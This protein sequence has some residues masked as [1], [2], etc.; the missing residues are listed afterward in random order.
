MEP[1]DGHK[2]ICQVDERWNVRVQKRKASP[3]FSG[4]T[5]SRSEVWHVR[6][7]V[8][9]ALR[10]SFPLDLVSV[11]VIDPLES[12]PSSE[13]NPQDFFLVLCLNGS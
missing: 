7:G 3:A 11:R 12:L 5:R 1:P 6:A 10:I 9:R 8:M 13:H 2:K 4:H